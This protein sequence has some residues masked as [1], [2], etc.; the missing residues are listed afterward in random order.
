MR[1][2]GP[3][4]KAYESFVLPLNYTGKLLHIE[5]S[6]NHTIFIRT[7][8]FFP[9][10]RYDGQIMTVI[11]IGLAASLA[12]LIG[13]LLA[14]HFKDH[15]HL[16]LGFSAGAVIGV[17]FFDLLPEALHIGEAFY[18]AEFLTGLVALGFV[19]Y[20]IFDRFAVIAGGDHGHRGHLGAGTLVIHSFLDGLAIGFAF[21]VSAAVGAVVAIAV[22]V[23]DFSDGLNTVHMSIV[24]SGTDAF[25]RRWLIADTVAPFLGVTATLFFTLPEKYLGVILALFCGFFLYIG[26]SEL[27]PESHHRHPRIWTSAATVIGILIMY[28]AIQLAHL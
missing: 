18:S 15:L 2:I 27:L 19:S 28:G 3:L 23:H 20:M 9:K 22:L 8:Q 11:L 16:I 12:T 13:G 25:A 24:G 14:F 7:L 1:G 10:E 17:A 21:Q 5:Q 4:S 6:E 26:A